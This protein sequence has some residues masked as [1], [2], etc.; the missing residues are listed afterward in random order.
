MLE[1]DSSSYPWEFPQQILLQGR[2]FS[3]QSY[4]IPDLENLSPIPPFICET[5]DV[6]VDE[7]YK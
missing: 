7:P 4:R 2:N 6:P 3:R 5:P 1:T